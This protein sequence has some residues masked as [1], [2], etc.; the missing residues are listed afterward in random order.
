MMITY[1]K[2]EIILFEFVD[3]QTN[4]FNR[5]I[6]TNSMG[7]GISITEEQAIEIM[8]RE[9][10]RLFEEREANRCIVSED[11]ALLYED[12]TNEIQFRRQIAYLNDIQGSCRSRLLRR[13]QELLEK[14][15]KK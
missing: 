13:Q 10:K 14:N 6:T 8:K 11:G 12:F 1:V 5:I 3:M 9:V 15:A 7:S 4:K 2:I